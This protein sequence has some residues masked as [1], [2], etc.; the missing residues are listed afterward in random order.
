MQFAKFTW[1]LVIFRLSP[2]AE[3]CHPF[4]LRLKPARKSKII[5]YY[6]Q[7]LA[8]YAMKHL[9]KNI[10]LNLNLSKCTRDKTKVKKNH[11][12]SFPTDSWFASAF[13]ITFNFQF[14]F[15]IQ[16]LVSFSLKAKWQDYTP[17]FVKLLTLKV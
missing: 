2:L 6:F 7:N 14:N 13:K 5:R 8:W 9:E 1:K 11:I 17:K 10:L 4:L 3:K 12:K 15:Q 16:H